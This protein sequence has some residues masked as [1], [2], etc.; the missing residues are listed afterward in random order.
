MIGKVTEAGPDGGHMVLKWKGEV[1]AD[2]PLAPLADEAPAYDRPWTKTE[3]P[4]PLADVPDSIDIAD[5]LLKLMA[6]PD[7]ASRRW[8]WQQYDQKV[9]GDTVQP[10][11]GD[12]A[13]VRVHGTERRS[14]SP[15]IARRVIARP[16]LMKAASRRSPRRIATSARSAPARSPPP[17][18]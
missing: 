2:I 5:D 15:P 9:G 6:S 13:I 16:T 10:P 1:A 18:A 8:I 11:G 3:P 12:A 14:P 17:T 7:I 4:A